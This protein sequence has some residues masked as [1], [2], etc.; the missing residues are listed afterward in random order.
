MKLPGRAFYNIWEAAARWD[1][2]PS[3]IIEWAT[4]GHIPIVASIPRF[5]A[6]GKA[7]GGLFEL[8]ASDL[9]PY[10]PRL[11]MS[12]EKFPV[13]NVR[14]VNEE[15]PGDWIEIDMDCDTAISSLEV[16]IRVSD[17]RGFEQKT[18]IAPE[19]TAPVAARHDWDGMWS[20]VVCRVH[21]MGIPD[22]LEQLAKECEDW[23]MRR[24][25]TKFPDISTIKKK[26]RPAYR[27]LAAEKA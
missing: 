27:E 23:F 16:L 4:L 1:C 9:L 15:E 17:A 6:G 5:T 25:A 24:D 12:L 11:G 21:D 3:D 19:N 13:F 14:P 26:V 22:T 20:F 8:R 2:T 7:Y 10:F 18:G